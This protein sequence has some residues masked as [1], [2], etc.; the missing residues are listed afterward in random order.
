MESKGKNNLA[1]SIPDESCQSELPHWKFGKCQLREGTTTIQLV[2]PYSQIYGKTNRVLFT[3]TGLSCAIEDFIASDES[4]GKFAVW[5]QSLSD[6]SVQWH[7]SLVKG[8]L[9]RG[10]PLKLSKNDHTCVACCKG[11]QH[12]ALVI[13]IQRDYSNARTPP[14]NRV[15]KR[16]NRTLIEAARTMLADSKLPTMFWT[17]AVRTACYVLK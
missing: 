6:E 3:D 4:I 10:L 9:V 17:E 2:P 14:Q 7:R 13:R 11:K 5:W 12:K 16:K 8:N 1:Q 15:A